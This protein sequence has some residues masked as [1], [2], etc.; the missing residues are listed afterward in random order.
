MF[1]R[2]GQIRVD[3]FPGDDQLFLVGLTFPVAQPRIGVTRPKVV[4][5]EVPAGGSGKQ[6]E[7]ADGQDGQGRA[8]TGEAGE[9]GETDR[10]KSIRDSLVERELEGLRSAARRVTR[11]SFLFWGLESGSSSEDVVRATESAVRNLTLALQ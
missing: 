3:W 4:E 10:E 2:G 9:A 1:T 7:E 8:E 6:P 11:L 5:A